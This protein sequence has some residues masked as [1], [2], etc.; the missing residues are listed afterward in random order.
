MDPAGAGRGGDLPAR[1]RD[2]SASSPVSH[3]SPSSTTGRSGASSRS[4]CARCS[5]AAEGVET[6]PRIVASCLGAIVLAACG[7]LWIIKPPA[8][9]WWPVADTWWLPGGIWTGVTQVGVR[10]HRG[11]P[12]H[13]QLPALPRPPREGRRAAQRHQG[14]R[15]QGRGPHRRGRRLTR[16][17]TRAAR[18]DT[19]PPSSG[20]WRSGSALRS[21]RRGHWFEPS[22]AHQD[23][24]EP[25][26][27]VARL[28]CSHRRGH[29]FEP[30]IAHQDHPEPRYHVARLC[31]QLE[32]P[33][34]DDS[35]WNNDGPSLE[36]TPH[37]RTTR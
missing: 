28:C 12:D 29:W 24:P 35:W 4:G 11:R 21:H 33:P 19:V 3:F 9:D 16:I 36:V 25:R 13:L 18:W 37:H 5:G 1:A 17:P 30:S 27:H 10:P 8:P 34:P 6:W 31:C 15:P 2:C 7:V 23:H 32:D 26:Y 22:I 14:A 20:D